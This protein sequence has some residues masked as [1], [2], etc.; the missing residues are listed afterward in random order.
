MPYSPPWT[1][2]LALYY[3]LVGKNKAPLRK[4]YARVTE[5]AETENFSSGLKR[6]ASDSLLAC[7]SPTNRGRVFG[8]K[9]SRHILLLLDFWQWLCLISSLSISP[10]P[11]EHSERAADMKK[12]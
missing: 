12:H 2:R 11:D 10:P 1:D 8:Q 5:D 9:S 6:G 3:G 4:N 7:L